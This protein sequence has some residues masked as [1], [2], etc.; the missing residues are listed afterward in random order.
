MIV[1]Y[2][3]HRS[4]ACQAINVNSVYIFQLL[5]NYKNDVFMSVLLPC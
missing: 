4:L 3:Q 1:N 2:V 5:G